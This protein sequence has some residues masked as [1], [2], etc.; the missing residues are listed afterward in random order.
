MVTVD[1][2]KIY[3]DLRYDC[4]VELDIMDYKHRR[5]SVY[6]GNQILTLIYTYLDQCY[7]HPKLQN[8]ECTK[9]F[10]E[11][12]EIGINIKNIAEILYHCEDL[13]NI[14]FNINKNF[15]K[16]LDPNK[17][18]KHTLYTGE[19]LAVSSD[20]RINIVAGL[21]EETVTKLYEYDTLQTPEFSLNKIYFDGDQSVT[22]SFKELQV[23]ITLESY[24]INTLN[25]WEVRSNDQ[26]YLDNIIQNEFK[27]KGWSNINESSSKYYW[28]YKEYYNNNKITAI[29]I[30]RISYYKKTGDVELEVMYNRGDRETG[31]IIYNYTLSNKEIE[32]AC[33]LKGISE[34]KKY[35]NNNNNKEN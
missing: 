34:L 32:L 28:I 1:R 10:I 8:L 30:Y 21:R 26:Y 31:S 7:V 24:I 18:G 35:N 19:V 23:D 14:Y 2:N 6:K 20:N 13:I 17:I 15:I 5:L 11:N 16:I 3:I 22:N 25:S 4:K 27:Y 33:N 29:K 12:N 9:T